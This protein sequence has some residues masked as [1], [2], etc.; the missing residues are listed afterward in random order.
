MGGGPISTLGDT[1]LC[2][3]G[4]NVNSL[5]DYKTQVKFINKLKS[6][7]E[8]VFV[9]SDTHLKSDSQRV[10]GEL[11]GEGAMGHT[12]ILLVVVKGV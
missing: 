11:W 12:L 2:I 3:M 8:N 5:S 6:S 10:F 1:Q 4:W 9:L 7:P